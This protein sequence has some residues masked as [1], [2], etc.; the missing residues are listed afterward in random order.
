MDLKTG[1]LTIYITVDKPYENMIPGKRPPLITNMYVEV[2]LKG[3]ALPDRF[4]VPRSAV[5]DKNV[6]ICTPENRLEIRP[7]SAEFN[8]A[9]MTVLSQ[10][11]EQG[12]ILVLAD[13]VPAVQGMLL[14]PVQAEEVLERLTQQALG[15][16]D[17]R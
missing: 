16:T 15:E 4:V 10:G 12:E 6:Y 14:K 2:E 3:R 1:A 8:M 11:L 17:P 5:H 13:L 9:D 7:V